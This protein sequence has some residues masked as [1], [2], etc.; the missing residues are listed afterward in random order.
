MSPRRGPQR[1]RDRGPGSNACVEGF[2]ARRRH[3]GRGRDAPAAGTRR[4]C[5]A[6]LRRRGARPWWPAPPSRP[7]RCRP[8]RWPRRPGRSGFRWRWPARW[9]RRERPAPVADDG[10]AGGDRLAVRG[11]RRPG[12]PSPGGC[13]TRVQAAPPQLLGSALVNRTLVIVKPDG[14]ERGLVGEIVGRLER[15]GLRLVAAELRTIDAE[16]AAAATTPSTRQALLRRSGGLHH[17]VA[18]AGPGGGGPRATTWRWCAP[19]W[20]RPTPGG[21]PG[22]DPRRPGDRAHREPR[23]RLG[24]G[25]V[26]GR[27][28][29]ALLPDLA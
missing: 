7:G 12:A 6:P 15:K 18:V 28:R 11:G 14:V 27:A 3:G 2:A 1:G 10:L 17:P 24:L 13:G 9:P 26:G 25:G 23:P 4:P 21:A 19:S 22:H 16:T 5:S 8:N 29:S 20:A